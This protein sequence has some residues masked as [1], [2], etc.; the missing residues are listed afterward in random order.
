VQSVSIDLVPQE[1]AA[2]KVIAADVAEDVDGDEDELMQRAIAL[3]LE[4]C[5]EDEK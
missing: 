5:S 1:P 3:S 4:P 2:E